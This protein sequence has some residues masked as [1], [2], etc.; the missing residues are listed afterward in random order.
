MDDLEKKFSEDR[1]KHLVEWH[2]KIIKVLAKLCDSEANSFLLDP[3]QISGFAPEKYDLNDELLPSVLSKL[4]DAY[5]QKFI[6]EMKA[7][8][9]IPPVRACEKVFYLGRH[10]FNLVLLREEHIDSYNGR[11]RIKEKYFLPIIYR[12]LEHKVSVVALEAE[13]QWIKQLTENMK[14]GVGGNPD[15]GKVLEF[16][17]R[18]P[19]TG[20]TEACLTLGLQL[21][22]PLEFSFRSEEDFSLEATRVFGKDVESRFI[23]VNHPSGDARTRALMVHN[24]QQRLIAIAYN[25]RQLTHGERKERLKMYSFDGTILRSSPMFTMMH[26]CYGGWLLERAGIQKYMFN[27]SLLK[28]LREHLLH[29]KSVPYDEYE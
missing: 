7:L 21:A 19:V 4:P 15:A 28:R 2:Q 26:L 13:R 3:L 24:G 23:A 6:T 1:N 22:L 9:N 11:Q 25:T 8:T 20:T 14:T 18:F 10:I 12:I 17:K 5:F 27:Y 29:A 16:A